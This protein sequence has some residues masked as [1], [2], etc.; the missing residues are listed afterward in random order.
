MT[1][2][3]KKIPTFI[4]S[5]GLESASMST[6]I[7]SQFVDIRNTS[8]FSFQCVWTGAPT[9]TLRIEV[10]NMEPDVTSVW[11]PMPNSSISV[12]TAGSQIF[13]VVACFVGWCRI[14]WLNTSGSGSLE[15]HHVAKDL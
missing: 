12:T 15:V 3:N 2:R 1:Y 8:G 4:T 7:V 6:S 13:D 14:S 9:G 5:T 11:E 10:T